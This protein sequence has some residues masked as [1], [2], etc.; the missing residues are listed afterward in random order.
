MNGMTPYTPDP[1]SWRVFSLDVGDGHA[2]HVEQ[3]GNP[4]GVPVV[5]LHGG[6][7]SGMAVAHRRFFDPERYHIIQF[8]QRGCGRS[9][10]RGETVHNTTAH[11][12]GDIERLRVHLGIDRWLVLGGSWGA[13]LALAYA[14]ASPSRCLGLVLRGFFTGSADAVRQFFDGHRELS[15]AGHDHLAQL[16]PETWRGRLAD[17]VPT[18]M[19]G[20]DTELQA[21]VARAWQAWEGV[22][23]GGPVPDLSVAEHPETEIARIDKYRVQ[24]HY[25]VNACFL[26]PEWWL[27]AALRLGKLPVAI[28]HGADDRICPADTS[29]AL[30]R[31]LTG[32]VLAVVPGCRH[33]PFEPAMLAAIRACTDRFAATGGFD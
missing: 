7:A 31:Q 22:M 25:L 6:P 26:A 8:D 27:D 20:G 10:P 33:N 29:Q 5:C 18:V 12:L 1:Q 9:M 24:A 15:P 14:A 16:A 28:V 19:A 3:S 23:D 21:R 32:S 4:D 17:W 13:T 2:L 30:H 11:L